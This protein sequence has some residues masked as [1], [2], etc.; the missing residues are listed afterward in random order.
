MRCLS[1]VLAAGKMRL[2]SITDAYHGPD[3]TRAAVR[4]SRSS[5]RSPFGMLA[6][7][8]GNPSPI[9]DGRGAG[10]RASAG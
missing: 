10:V 5:Q 7:D 8:E 2:P 4:T 6:V 9:E 3:G 1:D